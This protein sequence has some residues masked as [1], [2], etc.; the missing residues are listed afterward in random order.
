MSASRLLIENRA[1]AT[2]AGEEYEF[3]YV[4]IEGCVI[5]AVR[6]PDERAGARSPALRERPEEATLSATDT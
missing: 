5:P 1:M 3:G 6:A 4:A 2:V